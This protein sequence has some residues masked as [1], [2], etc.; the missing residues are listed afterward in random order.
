MKSQI[1][2]AKPLE[3]WGDIMND[4]VKSQKFVKAKP[5]GSESEVIFAQPDTMIWLAPKRHFARP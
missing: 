3:N 4:P 5:V 1:G 2:L